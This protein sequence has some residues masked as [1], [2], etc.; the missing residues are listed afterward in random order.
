ML[1]HHIIPDFITQEEREYFLSLID[2]EGYVNHKSTITGKSSS[3]HFLPVE[4][5]GME[6][7][8]IMKMLPHA[9]Q[10]WHTDG[11][12]LRRHSVIIHPLTD[13]YAPLLTKNGEVTSTAI[14]NTQEEHAVFNNKH[15]RVNLQIPIDLPFEELMNNKEHQYWDMIESLYQ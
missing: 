12:N 5:R 10:P 15:V 13:N 11:V 8:S 2:S 4:F 9:E 7:I 3:L 6:R 14:V 1:S